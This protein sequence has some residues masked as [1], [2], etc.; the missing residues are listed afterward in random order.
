MIWCVGIRRSIETWFSIRRAGGASLIWFRGSGTVDVRKKNLK[1]PTVV[2]Q[3]NEEPLLYGKQSDMTTV[4]REVDAIIAEFI[5]GWT[6]VSDRGRGLEGRPPYEE[7][8]AIPSLQPVPP[9][10]HDLT[11]AFFVA[12]E[13]SRGEVYSLHKNGEKLFTMRFW[14]KGESKSALASTPEMA[15][16]LAAIK[17]E[18]LDQNLLPAMKHS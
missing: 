16:C 10:S 3:E 12:K 11:W 13:V 17:A 2:G 4:S 18:G 6:D 7:G 8:G 1:M 14:V 9:F 5:L 15:I